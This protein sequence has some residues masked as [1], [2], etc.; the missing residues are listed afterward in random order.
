MAAAI[1]LV[2][3]DSLP[4]VKFTIKDSKKAAQ[5]QE[6]DGRDSDTWAVVPLVGANVFATASYSG[7]AKIIC[8][9]PCVVASSPK[10]EVILNFKDTAVVAEEGDYEVEVTVE[11]AGGGSQTIYNFIEVSVRARHV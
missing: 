10:G 2:Q 6:L 1:K 3:G 9:I 8:Q 11:Y 5:G 4:G 7:S